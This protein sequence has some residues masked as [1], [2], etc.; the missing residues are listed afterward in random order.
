MACSNRLTCRLIKG[1]ST[2]EE[3]APNQ[4]LRVY[5]KTTI[6]SIFH[7]NTFEECVTRTNGQ[8]TALIFLFS[9]GR[10]LVLIGGKIEVTIPYIR[11][12]VKL[13]VLKATGGGND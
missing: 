3:P 11:L 4:V 2:Q 10:Q 13:P 5:A 1:D 8:Q 9:N 12:Y 7:T 6:T